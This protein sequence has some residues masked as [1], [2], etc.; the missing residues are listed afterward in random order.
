MPGR[1]T[2]RS[3]FLLLGA[4]LLAGAL[5]CP[6]VRGPEARAQDTGEPRYPEQR[7][8]AGDPIPVMEFEDINGNKGSTNDYRDWIVVFT[9]ADRKSSKPLM[10]WMDRAWVKVSETDIDLNMVFFNVADL[11]TL[12]KALRG[13]VYPFLRILNDRSMKSMRKSYEKK[14][15]DFDSIA[16]A[17][18]FIPD[19]TGKFLR[20]FGLSDGKQYQCFITVGHRVVAVFDPSTPDIVERYVEAVRNLSADKKNKPSD[21]G[22]P[23]APE[24]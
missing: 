2:I 24:S 6:S 17:I 13:V 22:G 8:K 20:T 12:P 21:F 10:E 14:G 19:D 15:I 11:V 4:A 18:H 5:T 9:F 3:L 1:N 7:L 16:Q 23:E